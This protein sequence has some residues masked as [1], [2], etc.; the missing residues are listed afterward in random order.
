MKTPGIT[1]RPLVQMTGDATFNEVF[2]DSVRVPPENVLGGLNNGW[3]VANTTLVHE[4]HMLGNP[5]HTLNLFEGLLRIARRARRNGRPAIE[6]PAGTWPPSGSRWRPCAARPGDLTVAPGAW[7]GALDQSCTTWLN[8]RIAG[9]AL[10]C[11]F[12]PAPAAR[13][14]SRTRPSG[15]TSSCSASA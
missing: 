12:R 13:S 5:M 1:V 8:H 7:R 6:D 4:R 2:F 9:M 3:A 11:S 15:P 14:T 10:G